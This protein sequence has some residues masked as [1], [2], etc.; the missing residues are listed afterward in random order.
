M[1]T[2]KISPITACIITALFFPTFIFGLTAQQKVLTSVKAD[3]IR[4]AG[5]KIY[6]LTY[7]NQFDV[8]NLRN[9][10]A[11][12]TVTSKEM[13]KIETPN[14]AN[15]LYGLLPGFS[16]EQGSGEPGFDGPS[17]KIRG[18]G[19]YNA[20]NSYPIYVDGFLVDAAYFSNLPKSE[21]ESISILK[22]AASLVAFGNNGANGVIW[23]TTP[24]GK[25]GKSTIKFN[26]QYGIA[27]PENINKPLNSYQYANLYNQAISND[28]GGIWNPYYSS[29]QLTA[30]KNGS[31]IN[32]DW[33]NQVLK[34]AAPYT[35]TNLKFSGGDANTQYN[36]NFDYLNQQGLYNVGNASSS[37]N[38][39][40]NRFNLT[41]NLIY[42]WQIFEAKVDI[43]TQLRDSKAPN[44]VNN[45]STSRIWNDLA[46]YPNNI[47]NVYDDS[48][49]QHF[50]GTSIYPNNPV[51]S[52][53]GLGWESFQSRYL[54]SNISL[55]EKLDFITRGLFATEAYSYMNKSIA[56]YNKTANYA[57][58]SNGTPTTTDLTTSIVATPLTAAGMSNLEQFVLTLGYNQLFGKSSINS[59]VNYLQNNSRTTGVLGFLQTNQ[60]INGQFNYTYDNRYTAQ[61]G[62]SY[63]GSDA[64]APGHQWNL[65]S[66]ISGGWIVSN[67]AFLKNNT[68]V[69]FLKIRAS[70]GKTG[71]ENSSLS[72]YNQG[73]YLY[74]QYYSS[75][76]A[77][78][79]GNPNPASQGTLN[80][81][82]IASII[83]PET[84]LKSNI[85]LDMSLFKKV[86]LTIDAFIDKRSG[87]LTQ[88]NTIPGQF[89]NLITY[90]NLGLMT[91]QGIE[92]S[93]SYSDY[94]GKFK[95]QIF[96]T[97]SFNQN[98]IDYKGEIAPAHDYNTTT[99]RP[100]GT[101][102]GLIADGFYNITDF[103]A[104]GTLKSGIPIPQFGHVQP[105]DLR[106]KDLD[107]DNIIDSKDM[108]AIGK[109]D[110]PELTYS[111]G[112]NLEY[113]GFDCNLLF[114][115]S[116]LASINLLSSMQ[117]VPFVNYAT[118]Y[119]NAEGAW[120]YYPEQGIDTR[121]TATF[122][123]LTTV[124]NSNNYRASTFW[125]KN[126][127]F[128]R[129][130]N[131]QIGYS[132]SDNL[133]K[134]IFLTKLRIFVGA[135]NP[136]TWS[137]ILDNYHIDPETYN[138]YPA[139]KCLSMG[140][141]AN[142]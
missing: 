95:Y 141:S 13:D 132:F 59:M 130:R 111:F 86:D 38:E 115:G 119:S 16:V 52:I 81:S 58:Y 125:M 48:L 30:Y 134:K 101:P 39:I 41:G 37:S 74:Q 9:T 89:G 114:Q 1:I 97:T 73:R 24:K 40:Y 118:A 85:G 122:P 71:G 128:L 8:N 75:G 31:G 113:Q 100:F 12:S 62:F 121:A 6:R 139:M 135:T 112:V 28:N 140:I 36:I 124:A 107:G 54:I 117:T 66:A 102:M 69:N 49:H 84:S 57:R 14:M 65:Y 17:F 68:T 109:P 45:Y 105:G 136:V 76:G 110:Y 104:D 10:G 53:N 46:N 96:G 32:V 67:E 51:G 131:I 21:I 5:I 18:V 94:I 90:T 42:K 64:F 88:D 19:T 120:A 43:K 133:I 138:G 129:L 55:T 15:S 26:V 80:T 61:L 44:Y 99:G 142:F 116:S 78:Y 3:S 98:R 77:F 103:N 23:V 108:T 20:Y 27:T 126:N 2:K 35:S 127:D 72:I 47:Y 70:Y 87:I 91:N 93:I 7:D 60:N 34:T 22:D 11:V 63:Y 50:S 137:S 92:G 79:T 123:R 56:T 82:Y 4:V 25:I 83:G 33:Y 29:D 106:Y